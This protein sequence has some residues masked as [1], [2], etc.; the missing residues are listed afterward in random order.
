MDL[1][2]Y[3]RRENVNIAEKY[4]RNNWQ[5]FWSRLEPYMGRDQG[6]WYTGGI[7]TAGYYKLLSIPYG[8]ICNPQQQ[9][10]FAIFEEACNNVFRVSYIY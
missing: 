8:P 6:G 5:W 1:N 4:V 3:Y 7:N 9:E 10:L 2:P